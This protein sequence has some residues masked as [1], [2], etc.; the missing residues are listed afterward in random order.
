MRKAM[1][2]ALSKEQ[3]AE[4]EEVWGNDNS[5]VKLQTETLPGHA[6]EAGDEDGD[7][8][9]LGSAAPGRAGDDFAAR[10]EPAELRRKPAHSRSKRIFDV[11]AASMA[12]IWF[13]PV[14]AVIF[15]LVR[16]DGG[17]ALFVQQRVGR[18]NRLF[19]CYKF[20]SMVPDAETALKDL[21]VCNEQFRVAW[22]AERKLRNDPRITRFG[23]FL[24]TKSL[25]EL[26]QLWN[27]IRGDMSIVG[28]RPIVP[29]ELEKYGRDMMYYVEAK[30][31]LTGAWQVSGRNETT[32]EERIALDVDYTS[33]WTF[34]RDV[35]IIFKTVGVVLSGRGA[36]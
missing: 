25:D 7:A 8:E 12:L 21:L 36:L 9:T 28:P 22:D 26:P 3:V 11:A 33:N 23:A 24:R 6:N 5:V 27:I 29:E 10:A 1:Y 32:Y 14:L 17:P 34:W 31:G 35:K 2:A 4:P 30:P 16:R 15:F 13:M 20:R 18:D 19:P